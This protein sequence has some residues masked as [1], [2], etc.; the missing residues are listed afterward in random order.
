MSTRKKKPATPAT[1]VVSFDLPERPSITPRIG[2]IPLGKKYV[3]QKGVVSGPYISGRWFYED[4]DGY[5][6]TDSCIRSLL[7]DYVPSEHQNDTLLLKLADT[8][9]AATGV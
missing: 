7:D 9:R 3:S 1:K 8:L 2:F 4:R 5:V 6:Y